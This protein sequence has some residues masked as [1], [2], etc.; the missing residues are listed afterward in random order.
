MKNTLIYLS[1]LLITVTS[2]AQNKYVKELQ[3]YQYKQ[4]LL[5]HNKSTSPLIK[6]D[7]K[8]FKALDFFTIDEKFRVIATLT[9][10]P[11]TPIFEMPTTTSR[12]PMYRKYGMLTF[13]MDGKEQQLEI[14]QSQELDIDPMYKDMLFL[15]FTDKTSG[16]ESY[17]GGRYIDVYT[18]DIKNEKIS[19]DFNK[20]YNPYCAYNE[21]YS[22]P[23]TPKQNHITVP[24]KAGVKAFGNH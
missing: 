11:D 19:I 4:N 14:Y 13:I 10:T 8:K 21:R 20:A 23:I 2:I 1:F 22:C 5:F 18:T 12:K 24:I 7:F 3:N 6:E 15:P 9:K 17:G 16:H